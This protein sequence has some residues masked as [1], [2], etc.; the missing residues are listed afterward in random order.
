MYGA[1]GTKKV[2]G[3]RTLFTETKNATKRGEA[4]KGGTTK[5]RQTG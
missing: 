5:K 1:K 3:V 2:R 4:E